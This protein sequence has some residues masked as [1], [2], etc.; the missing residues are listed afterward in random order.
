MCSILIV[1]AD[2]DTEYEDNFD[3]SVQVN[4]R[5]QVGTVSS[6]S[7]DSSSSNNSSSSTT[8]SETSSDSNSSTP[9]GGS[10]GGAMP[11]PD[12]MFYNYSSTTSSSTST[13]SN[14]SSD[15]TEDTNTSL[16]D[17]GAENPQTGDTVRQ[18]VKAVAV[19]IMVITGI[20]LVGEYIYKKYYW[21]PYKIFPLV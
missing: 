8:S 11:Y 17:P 20:L 18:I 6:T 9:S 7:S 5:L 2:T 15:Y 19:W 12:D 14:T 1:F 21:L 3:G 13:S 4:F 10:G 16:K